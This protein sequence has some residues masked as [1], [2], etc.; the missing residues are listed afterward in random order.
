MPTTDSETCDKLDL[1]RYQSKLQRVL[2]DVPTSGSKGGPQSLVCQMTGCTTLKGLVSKYL[3]HSTLIVLQQGA[4][5]VQRRRLHSRRPWWASWDLNADTL[6]NQGLFST[7]NH[8]L[9]FTRVFH[10]LAIPKLSHAY[11]FRANS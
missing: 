6:D 1:A 3:L 2:E 9:H 4:G 8:G 10:V 11:I 7:S 5:L